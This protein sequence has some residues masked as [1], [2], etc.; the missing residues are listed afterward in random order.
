M[1]SLLIRAYPMKLI[2]TI[3]LIV[4]A[5]LP[6]QSQSFRKYKEQIAQYMQKEDYYAAYLTLEKA[7]EFKEEL[8]SLHM[9]AG[10]NAYQL[11]AFSLAVKHYRMILTKDIVVRNP[12]VEFYLG[13]SLFRQGIYSEALVYFK[14]FQSA[15]D[16]EHPMYA[17]AGRKIAS[18]QWAKDQIKNKDP[19]IQMKKLDDR[20]N[21]NQNEFSPVFFNNSLYVSSQSVYEK[22][23][24]GDAPPKNSGTIL[25]YDENTLKAMP[26]DSGFIEQ[27]VHMVHPT[28]SR[29]S[30]KLYFSI[31]SYLQDV[32]KLQ[33]QIYVKFKKGSFWGPK[34]K[35]PEP[36]NL[37]HYT[38]TQP[39]VSI[40]PE[41]GLDRLYFVSDRPGGKGGLDIYSC[42]LRDDEFPAGAD[43]L[44]AINT[45]ETESS[46]YFNPKS[47]TLFFSSSGHLGF[48]GLDVYRYSIE[49]KEANQIIN[50]GP[51]INSSYDDIFYKEDDVQRKAYMVS[52]KP[53]SLYLDEVIQACCY[54]IYKVKY[55]PA[56]LDLIVHTL[57]KYDSSGLFGVKL[58]IKD[59]TDYDSLHYN[60]QYDNQSAHQLKIVEDRK[61]QLIAT[62]NG[63]V[64]DTVYCTTIDLQDFSAI[65]KKLYL[66]EI[67][68]L[69]A[70]T[71]ERTTNVNLKGATV[72][73][74]DMDNNQLIKKMT[75]PDS[76]FFDFQLLKGKNYKLKAHKPKY[77]SAEVV[78]TPLET[79][80]EP[81]LNRKLFL[82]LTAI[83]DLRK[84][85]P[86]RLFFEND[87]PDPRSESD[88]TNVGFLDIYNDYYGKKLTYI[89][90]FTRGMK[91]KDR[92]KTILQID[93]FFNYNV[94]ANAEKLR[95]FM[96]KLIII[97]EEGHQ[98]D[99][100]LKGYASPRAKSDYN[101][102]LSSRRVFSV[103]NEFDRYNSNVFHDY[104]VDGHFQIKEIP[105]GESKASSD[106]SDNLEDTRNSIYN[107]K[108]ASERRVEILEILKGVDEN[109]N[110]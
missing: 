31:C 73:L 61:Y 79:A 57:D 19:L 92:E 77:E 54:D 29:D 78:I 22:V 13:E 81:V 70:L 5:S 63:W 75:N 51:S 96:D 64:G 53:A 67:K 94:K 66:T 101:Q 89:K 74:W 91:N 62:K 42:L 80:Q 60:K 23:L 59:I 88:R 15:V 7:F 40:D 36:I 98:I 41:T 8:D 83:A 44:D 105:F 68:Q 100:F 30:A 17:A 10:F 50:L 39:H 93:T 69:N 25:R 32:D 16:A 76:N 34:I 99:I 52:N 109:E 33:C 108:A 9:L 55:I 107:L 6:G 72:E 26:I 28:F 18:I 106:V 27:G 21:T 46:P 56:T 1:S 71:F 11:N 90:E 2:L 104:I 65:T 82:E 35:L 110:Q 87:M 102:L 47:K 12:I 48:G 49:G 84:L 14:S 45:P 4:C 37:P 24:K 97:L 43:N 95:L 103:R 38:S 58:E 85:L 3:F 20:I 86:I